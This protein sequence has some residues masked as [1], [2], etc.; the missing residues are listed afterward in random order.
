MFN[1]LSVHQLL[2]YE[3]SLKYL[4]SIIIGFL[5]LGPIL[6]LNIIGDLWYLTV[7]PNKSTPLVNDRRNLPGDALPKKSFSL[8]DRIHFLL[9]YYS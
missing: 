6:I 5:W 9:K 8:T 7:W 1:V 2:F 3:L 4:R